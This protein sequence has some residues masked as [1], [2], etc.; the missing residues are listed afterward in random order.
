MASITGLSLMGLPITRDFGL[1]LP[2]AHHLLRFGDLRWRHPLDYRLALIVCNFLRF[3]II[4]R[5][6]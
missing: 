2:F 6:R 4:M 3:W 1:R 5:S